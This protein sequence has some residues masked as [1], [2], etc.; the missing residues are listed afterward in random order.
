MSTKVCTMKYLPKLTLQSELFY[1][2]FSK[3][4][5]EH[6][7]VFCVRIYCNKF[8]EVLIQPFRSWDNV[9]SALLEKTFK[10]SFLMLVRIVRPEREWWKDKEDRWIKKPSPWPDDKNK[11]VV[12]IK[13]RYNNFNVLFCLRQ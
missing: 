13:E 2:F 3:L 9:E 4:I 6:Y 12:L 1:L 11:L 8:C 10:L 7:S 5:P